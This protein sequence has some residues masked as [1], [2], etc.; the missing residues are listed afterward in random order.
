[1][2]PNISDNFLLHSQY[3]NIGRASIISTSGNGRKSTN[4]L[5]Y[6]FSLNAFPFSSCTYKFQ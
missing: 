3:I 5:T 6:E 2:L 1:M 4:L